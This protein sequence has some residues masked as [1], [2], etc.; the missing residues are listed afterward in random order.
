MGS[1]SM[2]DNVRGAYTLAGCTQGKEAH[3]PV[4]ALARPRRW[5]LIYRGR[6]WHEELTE[7]PVSRALIGRYPLLHGREAA[8]FAMPTT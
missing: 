4:V 5:F 2:H 1:V 3:Q 8:A 6:W 7:N